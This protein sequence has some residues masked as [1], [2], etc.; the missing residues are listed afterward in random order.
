MD[1]SL[2][3]VSP[4]ALTQCQYQLK[5]LALLIEVLRNESFVSIVQTQVDWHA[6]SGLLPTSFGH[7][8]LMQSSALAGQL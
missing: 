7:S 1:D 5:P 8:L 3:A 6:D 2:F 4:Q